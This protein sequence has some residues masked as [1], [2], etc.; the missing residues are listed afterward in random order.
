MI[1]APNEDTL[2]SPMR[3]SSEKHRR[4]GRK[5]TDGTQRK[6]GICVLDS[7]RRRSK[8]LQPTSNTHLFRIADQLYSSKYRCESPLYFYIRIGQVK[9]NDVGGI[10]EILQNA[11]DARYSETS[12]PTLSFRIRPSEMI[13]DLNEDGFTRANVVAICSTGESSKVDDPNTTGKKGFG[14]KSIFGIARRVHIQSGFWSFRFEHRRNENGLGM[15][16]PLWTEPAAE[17][18]PDNVGTRFRLMYAEDTDRF[19]R[20]LVA[21]FEKL[22]NTTI[23]ATRNIKRLEIAFEGV[24]DRDYRLS[25]EKQGSFD[26]DEIRILTRVVGQSDQH[27]QGEMK[28]RVFKTTFSDLPLDDVRSSQPT[29]IVVG[30]QVDPESGDC[31]IPERGQQ[32]FAFLPVKRLPQLPVRHFQ[33]LSG[34]VLMIWVVSD[35]S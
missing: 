23:F 31:Y 18:L 9:T 3:L 24:A 1:S 26:Q 28:I 16:T 25:F 35:P 6:S 32:I 7:P 4:H 33:Y 21:E 13:I 8:I 11:D 10:P 14:F 22:S 2:T 19:L 29:D 12:C 5:G 34:P 15:V 27:Q 30:F 17:F 20:T